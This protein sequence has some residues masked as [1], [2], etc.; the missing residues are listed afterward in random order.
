VRAKRW[1]NGQFGRTINRLE[2]IVAGKPDSRPRQLEWN[3]SPAVDRQGAQSRLALIFLLIGGI[4]VW[5]SACQLLAVEK[6]AFLAKAGQA[7]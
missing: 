7:L 5:G 1:K 3:N 2:K 4:N 6:R